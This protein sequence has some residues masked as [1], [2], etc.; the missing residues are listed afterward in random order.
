MDITGALKLRR[1]I[2][3]GRNNKKKGEN[4]V[5]TVDKQ[6]M[7]NLIEVQRETNKKVT[8]ICVKQ[9]RLSCTLETLT[10]NQEE[11]HE[12]L[13]DNKTGLETR[14]QRIENYGR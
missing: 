5:G 13:Y 10:A 9:A 11:H 4:V 14:V 1:N 2:T 7:Q 8:E 3:Q 6:D 12:S